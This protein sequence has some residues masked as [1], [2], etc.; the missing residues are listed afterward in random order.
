MK[1]NKFIL[2]SDYATLQNTGE[3]EISVTLPSSYYQARTKIVEFKASRIVEASASANFRV[4]F[5]STAY[6]YAL[7]G[8]SECILP[9]GN[10][11]LNVTIQQE[12]DK[13]TLLI[14]H[15]A[16]TTDKTFTGTAQTVT[17]HIQT[18]VDPF[19]G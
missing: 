13:F 9:Y 5:T 8:C 6:N 1:A 11:E 10:D 14:Y 3:F 7:T 2:N 16:L 12:K 15:P 18:F 4:Y 17:A 19:T